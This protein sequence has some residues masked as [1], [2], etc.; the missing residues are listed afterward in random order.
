[1][2]VGVDLRPC[3]PDDHGRV[4]T[5]HARTG[6]VERRAIRHAPG[7]RSEGVLVRARVGHSATNGF[8]GGVV[9][10]MLDGYE[11]VVPCEPLAG[12]RAE[13]EGASGCETDDVR[14]PLR[15]SSL[16]T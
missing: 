3:G 10:A 8:E 1:M 6:R 5:R 4:T 11:R 2:L 15:V 14:L 9:H 7:Y 13:R 16:G 12:R